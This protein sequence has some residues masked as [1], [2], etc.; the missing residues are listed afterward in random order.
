[1]ESSWTSAKSPRR[2][3]PIAPEYFRAIAEGTVDWESWL[4]GEGEVLWVNEAVERFT[5]YAPDEC[6]AMDD[7]PLPLIVPDDRQRMAVHM[8]DAAGGSTKNNIEFRVLHRDGSTP[9]VAISWQPLRGRD[10]EALGF[11]ASVRDVTE[12]HAMREQLRLQNEHLEQLV[13]E[14]TAKIAQLEEH[15]L[16]MEQLAAIG[17]L[18]AGVAH[19]INNPL[20]GIRNAFAL[21][22]RHLSKDVKHYDKLELID[23]E[24]ERISGI[25][26]QMYQ[27]YRPSEQTASTFSMDEIQQHVLSL[28]LPTARKSRVTVDWDTDPLPAGEGLEMNEV[29]LRA[30]EVKQILINLIHN[31][32]QASEKGE[33]VQVTV[34]PSTGGVRIEV[35]D[36]GCGV[37]DELR[38]KIFFPFVS[39]KIAKVGQGMGLGLSVTKG[40]VEGMRGDI[41]LQSRIGEG[42]CFTVELPRRLS[43]I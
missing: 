15:R 29:H 24:I 40:L 2:G 21:L 30:G 12:K 35:T 9:W 38:E 17:E 42:T 19:E 32:I 33:R 1:M 11:R 8:K 43:S 4:S 39:T 13:Q 3:D 26:H 7:Y 36:F 18:A 14:R 5:G 28:T 25:T 41:R 31:A 6:L 22:K 34:K 37:P 10:G 27:L 20:A 23:D 16:K